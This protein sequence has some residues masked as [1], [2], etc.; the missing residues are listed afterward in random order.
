MNNLSSDCI[1]CKIVKKE[2]STKIIFEN[3]DCV[4]F[5]DIK[6]VSPTH[7][8]VIPKVHIKNLWETDDADLLGKLLLA[9]KEIAKQNNLNEGFRT[10]INTGDNGGQTVYHLHLHILGGR[11]HKWP[12]G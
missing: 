2:L 7:I 1:F 12:P 5:N 4:A 10:V 11:F 9:V 8:L 3:E 6:P